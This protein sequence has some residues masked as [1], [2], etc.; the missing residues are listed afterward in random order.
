M[1]CLSIGYACSCGTSQS[2]MP[3][4]VVSHY[5]PCLLVWYVTISHVCWCGTILQTMPTAA[6]IYTS[7]EQM[8]E[9]WLKV[10]SYLTWVPLHQTS[11]HPGS[12]LDLPDYTA[13]LYQTCMLGSF[14]Q[15]HMFVKCYI[16]QGIWSVTN[17]S[18]MLKTLV[19][20]ICWLLSLK[21]PLIYQILSDT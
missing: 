19:C 7:R 21:P 14:I 17:P 16:R 2:A 9:G 12:L 11:A 5:R 10:W 15:L 6:Y 20:K 13:Q 1:F 3:S 8:E 4:G 18:D